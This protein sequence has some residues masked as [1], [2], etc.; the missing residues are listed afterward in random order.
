M[1]IEDTHKRVLE[2]LKKEGQ[3]NTF[4]LAR[5]LGIDR[6]IIINTA[7]ELEEKHVIGFKSGMARFLGFPEEEK[8]MAEKELGEELTQNLTK[9]IPKQKTIAKPKSKKKKEVQ[10]VRVKKKAKK[11]KGIRLS[12]EKA[13]DHWTLI[14]LDIEKL[15]I[16]LKLLS[17]SPNLEGISKLRDSIAKLR[18]MI[19]QKKSELDKKPFLS[20]F[21]N[22]ISESIK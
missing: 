10:K 5:V 18:S 22:V 14:K 20:V 2:Y 21:D 3:A 12:K 11:I 4:R 16:E 7:K 17:L 8:S 6:H 19:D 9:E 15:K 13:S 1:V